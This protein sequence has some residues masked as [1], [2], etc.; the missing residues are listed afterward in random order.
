MLHNQSKHFKLIMCLCDMH[1]CVNSLT[2][3]T[4]YHIK[5]TEDASGVLF[6]YSIAFKKT[7]MKSFFYRHPLQ[8]MSQSTAARHITV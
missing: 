8:K 3:K 7:P 5:A 1:F 2:V 4:K 6:E